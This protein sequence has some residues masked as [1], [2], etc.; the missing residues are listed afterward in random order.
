[1]SNRVD[2]TSIVFV[3]C[4]HPKWSKIPKHIINGRHLL[5]VLKGGGERVQKSKKESYKLDWKDTLPH[6][7]ERNTTRAVGGCTELVLSIQHLLRDGR[8]KKVET[9][10]K[11]SLRLALPQ[12]V[13][14]RVFLFLNW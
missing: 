7:H 8:W 6:P 14:Q 9:E 4:I 13:L 5:M 12:A 3:L 2:E 1:M 10:K 11:E